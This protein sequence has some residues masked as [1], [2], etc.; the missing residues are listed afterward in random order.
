MSG[1]EFEVQS[2]SNVAS[3]L[4]RTQGGLMLVDKINRCCTFHLLRAVSIILLF[5]MVPSC[6]IGV[7]SPFNA[8]C[9]AEGHVAYDCHDESQS[10]DKSS[11]GL[12]DDCSA[13]IDIS[14]PTADAIAGRTGQAVLPL[15]S[16]FVLTPSL[17]DFAPAPP[18]IACDSGD[19]PPAFCA[20]AY[21]CSIALRC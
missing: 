1:M 5:F 10:G 21:C 18:A 8:I 13:C 19:D 4:M 20:R 7:A 9:I 3:I 17:I 12:G 16:C 11:E 15:L 6:I 2:T 14:A